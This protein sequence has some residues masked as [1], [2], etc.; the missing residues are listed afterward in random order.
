MFKD[1]FA[2]DDVVVR[3]DGQEVARRQQI[4]TRHDV[5]PPLAWSVDVP[6]ASDAVTTEVAVPTKNAQGSL[7]VRVTQSPQVDVTLQGSSVVLRGSAIVPS[8]G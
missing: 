1:G 7:Q 8:I 6:V 4:T 2:N 3:I 5:E